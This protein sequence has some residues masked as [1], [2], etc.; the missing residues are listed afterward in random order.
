MK[1]LKGSVLYSLLLTTD[2]N[3]LQIHQSD[4]LTLLE[5]HHCSKMVILSFFL[6]FL[7]Y[8]IGCFSDELEVAR[9]GTQLFNRTCITCSKGQYLQQDE[10]MDCPIGKYSASP[11]KPICDPCTT[12]MS[13]GASTCSDCDIQ[14]FGSGSESNTLCS[15]A[16]LPQ[17]L[18]F[19]VSTS[20]EISDWSIKPSDWL[21]TYSS[22]G[23][24]WMRIGTPCRSTILVNLLSS[25]QYSS[26][27]T[28]DIAYSDSSVNLYQLRITFSG[29]LAYGCFYTTFDSTT[30]ECNYFLM[31]SNE[32]Y[33][34]IAFFYPQGRLS[35]GKGT[36]I[37]SNVVSQRYLTMNHYSRLNS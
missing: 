14:S 26:L 27:P 7:L 4:L 12:A 32:R 13:P 33:I 31:S 36:R 1:L 28:S 21:D 5:P 22:S 20:S 25:D 35:F 18:D 3:L 15:L 9:C 8:S 11:N 30:H 17:K 23:S 2:R 19:E 6:L 37:G 24:I 16:S 29:K 10:C 34:W